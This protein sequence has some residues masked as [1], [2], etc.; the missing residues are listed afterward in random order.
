MDKAI[1]HFLQNVE[2]LARLPLITDAETEQLLGPEVSQACAVMSHIN[3][4][5][6]LCGACQKRCCPLVKCELYDSRFSQCPIFEHRPLICRMHYCD[7][8]IQ[9]DKSFIR[10][11]ADI[12]VNALVE[13]KIQGSQKVNLFDSPPL[14]RYAPQLLAAVGPALE[15]FKL[16]KLDEKATLQV[17]HK[18]AEKF[19]PASSFLNNIKETEET[20][21]M[22]EDIKESFY[23]F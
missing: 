1:R 17:M 6:N 8:F 21:A 4:Q 12:Y 15:A 11:F 7:Q 5:K 19:R 13:A 16:G 20:A 18:E 10:E 2:S 22:W 9:T 23:R 3:Q 14:I